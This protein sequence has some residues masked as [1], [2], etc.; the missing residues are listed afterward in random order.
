MGGAV[1]RRVF[2]P[3][4]SDLAHRQESHIPRRRAPASHQGSPGIHGIA[5]QTEKICGRPQSRENGARN[6]QF[7]RLTIRMRARL[8]LKTWICVAVVVCTDAFGDFFMKRG[9]PA[10]SQLGTPLEYI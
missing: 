9:M 10:A 6:R 2:L 3:P 7:R 1:L 4:A 8:R 5:L